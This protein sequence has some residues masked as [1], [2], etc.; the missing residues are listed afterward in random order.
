MRKL[1]PSVYSVAMR[2]TARFLLPTLL[3]ALVATGC[4]GDDTSDTTTS[5]AAIT[6]T[7]LVPLESSSTTSAPTSTTEPETTTTI[8]DSAISEPEWAI[9]ER[10][11]SDDGATIVILLD[12]E[13]YERLTDI[14]IQ[15]VIED[16]I[17]LF[18]PI[19][20]AHVVDSEEAADIVL[21]DVIDTPD[22]AILDEH[23]L[24]RLEEGFRI[25]FVGPFAEFGQ[26]ILTS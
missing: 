17:D 5:L 10:V 1:G 22:Q 23:Y 12:P 6:T 20:E 9:T 18:P 14:D 11:E 7:S 3:V 15:N 25:V 13:S 21:S 26:I 8:G 19:Y 24:A 4:N 2:S 16:A